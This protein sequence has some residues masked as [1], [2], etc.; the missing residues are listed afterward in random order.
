MFVFWGIPGVA[1]LGHRSDASR[2]RPRWIAPACLVIAVS[3]CIQS[4]CR[5][6]E[7]PDDAAAHYLSQ[8]TRISYPVPSEPV[9]DKAFAAEP[10]RLGN[11]DEDEIWDV[12]LMEAVHTALTN[13]DIIRSSGQFLS[14]ANVLLNNP[15]ATPSVY[16]AAIQETGVLFGQR[17]VEAALS[18]FD[19][20]L[21]SSMLWGKNETIVNNAFE[22]GG[23]DPGDALR[24]DSANFSIGIRKRLA[25]GGQFNVA[26][27]WDYSQNNSPG[28]L[29]DSIYTG[30]VRAEFRQPLLAGA[31]SEYSRIAGPISDQLQGVTGVGQ[32]VL[33]AR[34][35]NDVAL[36]DF[37]AAS[38]GLLRDVERLYW[39]L[40]LAYQV[41]HTEVTA[42]NAALDA[43][44]TVDTQAATGNIGAV[45]EARAREF[46]LQ[47]QGRANTALD[48]LY[49]V[50]AEL[51]RIMGLPVNDGRVI[52]PVDEPAT[53]R[54]EPDWETA[55]MD[56]L[57]SRA[58]LR[59]QK[60]TIKS[61]ELQLRAA[62]QLKRPRLDF[63]SSYRVNGFGDDLFGDP[64]DGVS[65]NNLGSAYDSLSHNNETGW[66]LG[67]QFSLPVGLR[68]AHAQVR[69]FELRLQKARAAL[70][71]QEMEISHEV[72][73]AFRDLDRTWLAMQNTHSRRAAVAE[74][75]DALE[76][77]YRIEPTRVPIQQVLSARD[78]LAQAEISYATSV[79]EYN[80][81]VAELQFR[82]GKLLDYNSVYLTE[83][84]W[85][86]AAQDDAEHHAEARAR[87]RKAKFLQDVPEPF[88]R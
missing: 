33:I 35:N 40:V 41:Y 54:L 74:Q 57:G 3:A 45:D 18:E 47:L 17:G 53:V 62:R 22:S 7:K 25:G 8:A 66:N 63:V 55:L 82:T 37:E 50:E 36:A 83:G 29:F 31:G 56:A 85:D 86:A 10:R 26:H 43:W 12:T 44:R 23:L 19:S 27:D 78:A 67:L 59:R 15:A 58:E 76:A 11:D 48:N 28:R 38:A 64:N 39:Q 68:Y 69:N 80:S 84:P 87:S 88:A 2:L 49:A 77:E 60:W 14:P 51:R 20:Q 9:T 61:L 81:A 4:G 42:R 34:V 21:T 5:L 79:T 1:A 75:L 6:I 73:A 46:Y 32:G 24:E 13:N 71:A 16:D 30:S 72:A 52:R 65:A 70:A